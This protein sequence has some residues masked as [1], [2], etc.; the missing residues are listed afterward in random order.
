MAFACRVECDS[1]SP[2][3][4]RLTTFVVTYPRIIHAELLTHRSFSRNSASSRAI[5]VEKMI[6]MVEEDPYIPSEWG[7]NQKGMQAGENLSSEQSKVA[8]AMWRSALARAVSS[9]SHLTDLGVHKQLV[10]RLLEPFSWITVIITATDWANFFALRCHPDAHPE[11]QKIARMMWTAMA[12]STPAK[13]DW[14]WWHLPFVDREELA[15]VCA[16]STGQTR[17]RHKLISAGRSAR[18]S[19]L[20]HDGKRDPQADVDL[21][22]RLIAE[23]PRHASPFEHVATPKPGRH[24]NFQGWRQFRLD[25]PGHDVKDAHHDQGSRS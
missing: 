5:P 24:A 18:V 16:D 25:I 21:A 15:Q 20:T 19:Y 13:L 14:G 11:F 2:E 3:G 23:T 1:V 8:E 6:R 9:A 22:Q 10:N 7:R 17:E 4:I 12:A